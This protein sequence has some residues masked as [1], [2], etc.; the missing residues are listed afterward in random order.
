MTRIAVASRL[1]LAIASAFVAACAGPAALA[2]KAAVAAPADPPAV[3]EGDVT[4]AHVG[5]MVVL[6]KHIAGA[7]LASTQLYIRGGAR[8][9]TKDDAGVEMLAMRVAAHGGAGGLDKEAFGRRLSQLGATLGGGAERDWS[10]LGAKSPLASFDATF[11]LVADAFLR[12]ALPTGEIEL[13]RQQQLLGIK[14]MEQEPEGRLDELVTAALYKGHPY[15]NPPEG[16]V[17][18]VEKLTAAQVA[19][20]LAKLRETSRL[21]LAVAGDVDAAHVVQLAREAFGGLP[22]GAWAPSPVAPPVFATPALVTEARAL[23]TNYLQGYFAA[24]RAG[25][26]GYAAARVA[27]S[28]LHE[29]VFEEVRTKRNLSYAPGAGYTRDGSAAFGYVTVSAVDPNAAFT[30]MLAEL[31][32][33]QETP[34]GAVEL[35][36]TKA[37]LRTNYLLG[38]ETTDGQAGTLAGDLLQTGDWR[39]SAKLLAA[40]DAVTPADVQA[41]AK[42]Y[43]G[44]LQVVMLGDP[45]KL[46]PKLATSL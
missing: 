32:K 5:G 30:V 14:Q 4:E 22:R 1:T 39:Y 26:A 13:E 16:T 12:P 42:T 31:R 44:R 25:E 37:L 19:A 38:F 18:S 41:F 17:A 27:M 43:V 33:L 3:T 20:Q 21:V 29:R 8:D 34:L 11:A 36:G 10:S 46:D 28:A 23:P 15:A 7:E 40:L 45:A 2:P 6:V 9:W 35:A 24:P